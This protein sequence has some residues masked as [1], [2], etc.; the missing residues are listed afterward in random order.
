VPPSTKIVGH[1]TITMPG[2]KLQMHFDTANAEAGPEVVPADST[3]RKYGEGFMFTGG[4]KITDA[5]GKPRKSSLAGVIA[6]SMPS[7][8]GNYEHINTGVKYAKELVPDVVDVGGSP[9]KCIVLEVLYDRR[10][11]QPE[12]RSVKFVVHTDYAIFEVGLN[13]ANA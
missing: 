4:R 8:P 10:G 2:T 3:V 9:V 5:E 1:L 7:H 12:E 11:W 6:V 13:W